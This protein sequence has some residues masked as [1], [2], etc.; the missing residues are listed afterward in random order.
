MRPRWRRR[1][2]LCVDQ[3]ANQPDSKAGSLAPVS[4]APAEAV[5]AS[6]GVFLPGQ[7]VPLLG[8][9][10]WDDEPCIDE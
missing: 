1:D 7:A 10:D 6:W 9:R 3:V 5:R 8:E 4:E 2:P